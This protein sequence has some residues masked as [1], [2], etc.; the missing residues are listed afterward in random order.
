VKTGGFFIIK[1]KII[2]KITGAE[3]LIKMLEYRG[4]DIVSGI[5]GG[6]ILPL[7]N[8]L[9]NSKIKHVLARHEQGAGFI[10]QGI[11]RSRGE[12]AVCFATSGPGV[13]N[14]LTSIADAKMDSIPI[15]AITAQVSGN[16]IGSDAFQ[17]ID[18][19]G[20]TIPI[21]KHNFLVRDVYDLP[22]VVVEAFFIAESGRPGPVVIDVPKDVLNS[23]IEID[24]LPDFK[25]VNQIEGLNDSVIKLIA[26]KINKSSKPVIIAG[27]GITNKQ[28]A[29][30]L[31]C[32]AEKNGIPVALTLR[33]LGLMPNNHILNLGMLGMHG[34]VET[35]KKLEEADLVLAFGI[36]FDDRATGK[37]S[38]FCRNA[39]II[40]VDIDKSEFNKNKIVD[41]SINADINF[42][43]EDLIPAIDFNERKDWKHTNISYNAQIEPQKIIK[44]ISGLVSETSFIVTDVGQHQMWVAQSYPFKYPFKLLTSGGLGT[45]GF[46]LP[47]AIGASLANPDTKVVCI[48][49]DGSVMMNIQELS[50]L[51]EN[52][53]DVAVIVFNNSGLGMVRQQQ[54]LFYDK[55]YV[56][57]QFH[58][59]P[60]FAKIAEGFGIKGF[61]LTN[62][63]DII[64]DL[65]T[66]LSL[67][68]P[69]LINIPIEV[70]CNVMPIV[71]PGCA[72][73]SYII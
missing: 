60:D 4:I 15:I 61:D 36:R 10:A 25:R 2:M 20:L 13:T 48:S 7:Y 22:N 53:L 29:I 49:G 51:S 47:V 6:A 58:S 30:S 38:D 27:G 19:Y 28:A 65:K 43:L 18:T 5:P 44:K 62:S 59:Q 63:Q 71:M 68:E 54:E 33:G 34:S 12:V 8:A 39:F 35:N 24:K 64:S 56:A 46:G 52:N 3:F 40:H 16:L 50:T 57:S 21:T 37:V 11:S 55:N 73:T 31:K 1:T 72:N 70:D 66:A 41:L 14:L 23:I 17:E 32:L 26:E 69:V 42:L 45:M 9:R 67:R